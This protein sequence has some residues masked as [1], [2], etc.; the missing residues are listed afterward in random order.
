MSDIRRRRPRT[1]ETASRGAREP[2]D[3]QTGARNH[4][5]ILQSC[6]SGRMDF[7]HYPRGY[8]LSG[9][10]QNNCQDYDL[11]LADDDSTES[12]KSP[13]GASCKVMA[14]EEADRVERPSM[15]SFSL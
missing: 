8:I 15:L 12:G 1:R 13:L 14:V 6:S 9:K 5:L 10:K 11:Q 3:R 4:C 2:G 7:Y